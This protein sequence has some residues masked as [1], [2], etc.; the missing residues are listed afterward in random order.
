MCDRRSAAGPTHIYH[1]HT[2]APCH[3]R[4]AVSL[5]LRGAPQTGSG[6]GIL[7]L[8]L[9]FA[10]VGAGLAVSHRRERL[11]ELLA[12]R[13]PRPRSYTQASLLL[14]LGVL[15]C[16]WMLSYHGAHERYWRDQ[17]APGQQFEGLPAHEP[18]QPIGK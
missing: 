8:A 17:S 1:T 13:S 15:G 7:S 6:W 9:A 4:C 2:R 16:S 10:C 18:Y 11:L 5:A 3:T 12:Q 14:A